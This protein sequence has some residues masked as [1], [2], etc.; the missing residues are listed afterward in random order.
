MRSRVKEFYLPVTAIFAGSAFVGLVLCLIL[1]LVGVSIGLT[2]SVVGLVLGLLIPLGIEVRQRAGRARKVI[3]LDYRVHQFGHAVARGLMRSLNADK[4]RWQVSY[5]NTGTTLVDGSVQWQIREIQT[6]V[7]ED[8]DA[9]VLIPAGDDEALWFATASAIKAR[10][11]VV[12]VDTK[13][14]NKVYR[15]VGISPP[16]FVSSNYPTTGTLIGEKLCSWLLED[17]TR[18]CALWIGPFGSW[19]GEERSRNIVFELAKHT[20]LDRTTMIAMASWT[21]EVE[22]CR[23]TIA[24]VSKARGEVAVYT[25]DDENAIA[26][27]L[28]TL[29]ERPELRAKMCVIGCNATQDDWG[30]VQAFDLR[31]VDVTVD[32]LAEDQGNQAS[33]LL[34]KERNGKLDSSER[35]VF[36]RPTL[37]VSADQN[38]R[39]IDGIFSPAALTP[40]VPS[41]PGQ[42]SVSAV[43]QESVGI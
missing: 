23:E 34:V 15:D 42:L 28:L 10:T 40:E 17:S 2:L 16:R 38:R 3:I 43:S 22:R 24:L 14:P 20:L 21:P 18:T 41:G 26:L 1:T 13:P 32:I 19:P 39:W 6:A 29:S 4:R 9:I 36:I 11:F 37:L 27:H 5:K 30:N 25:A 33:M 31:A 35:S 8:F 12:V 7:L